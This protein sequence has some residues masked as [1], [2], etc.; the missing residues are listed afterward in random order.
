MKKQKY[1][2]TF[3][4]HNKLNEN[5]GKA[6]YRTIIQYEILSD[7]PYDDEDLETISNETYDGNWSGLMLE[8]KI[9]NQKLFGKEAVKA[10][11]S[12]GSDSEFFGLDDNG[13]E[14]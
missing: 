11:N 10:I 9:L 5:N 13:N 3:E 2:K 1:V 12:Q 7:E 14:I 8:P 4:K 6:I